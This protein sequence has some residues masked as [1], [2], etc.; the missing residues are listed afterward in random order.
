M[1]RIVSLFFAASLSLTAGAAVAGPVA[2]PG[3][4]DGTASLLQGVQYYEYRERPGVEFRFGNGP[5][6]RYDRN[7]DDRYERRYDRRYDRRW[8]RPPPPRYER[9]YD[10]RYDRRVERS[11]GNAHVNWCYN[12]YRSYRAYDNTFQPNYGP[13]QMCYSPFI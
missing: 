10:R 8:H 6:Y 3:L 4:P 9:R 11:P 12:R 1:N 2:A 13:R 7:W 5:D